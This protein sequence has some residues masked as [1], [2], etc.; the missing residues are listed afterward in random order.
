MQ[1]IV[2]KI[3]SG[4]SCACSIFGFIALFLNDK[5]K[6]LIALIVYS[7]AITAF[8]I[9]VYILVVRALSF[10]Y[11]NKYKRIA[12]LQTFSCEDQ[13]TVVFE[14]RKIIQA[15]TPFLNEV[16][17]K[18]K[19]QGSGNPVFKVNG[20]PIPYTSNGKN[21]VMDVVP[22]KLGKTLAYNET[23]S[24]TT[25][26]ECQ[27]SDHTAKFGCFVEEPTDFIQFR[28]LLGYKSGKVKPATLFKRSLTAGP[29]ASDIF[30]EHIDFDM[31]H[32]LYFK[33]IDNPEIGYNYFIV[34]DK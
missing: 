16:E 31:K 20:G 25:S 26:H 30:I 27:F 19:W 6:F 28:I 34:W 8:F 32:K 29:L 23:A 13:K 15:K 7:V 9:A 5:D 12:S 14:T 4:L 1:S 21:D 10:K 33:I 24:Y 18:R 11:K 3:F 2:F 17:Y 22:I